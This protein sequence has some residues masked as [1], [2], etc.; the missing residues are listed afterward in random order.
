MTSQRRQIRTA[1]IPMAP[2]G[3]ARAARQQVRPG[4]AVGTTVATLGVLSALAAVEHGVGEIGQGPVSPGG[5]VFR[6]WEGVAAFGPLDGEPA[7]SLVPHLLLSGILTILVALCLALGS[8]LFAAGR[9]RARNLIALSILLLLVGG[10]FGP[11]LLGLLAG[12]L[13]VRAE[14]APPAR[15]PARVSR[16]AARWWPGFLAAAALF[17]LG[18]V[19]GTAVLYLTA[20][21]DD[22]VLVAALT[23]GAFLSTAAALLSARTWDRQRLL[24]QG[25]PSTGG[26]TS[27]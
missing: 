20:G 26:R 27:S 1:V 11:P 5:L 19:P 23:A 2:T 17:F 12:A 21:V 10:G 13:A 9:V 4:T 25:A 8:V 16:V 22:P 24:R 3:A 7:M 14:H 15:P 18:L 6:S